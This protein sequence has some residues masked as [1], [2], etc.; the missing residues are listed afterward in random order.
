MRSPPRSITRM[1]S[2]ERSRWTIPREARYSIPCAAWTRSGSVS[3][4]GLPAYDVRG[5]PSRY[6]I[7]NQGVPSSSPISKNV[8]TF[9]WRRLLRI[10]ASRS[11][12]TRASRW[13]TADSSPGASASRMTLS[14]T[15]RPSRSST[16]WYTIPMPPRPIRFRIR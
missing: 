15:R 11:K 16:A 10:A 1:L 7:A 14:A 12:R 8:T 4:H 5:A 3:V 6:S 9:T 2:G 13:W